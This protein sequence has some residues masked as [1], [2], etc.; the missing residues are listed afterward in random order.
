[1]ARTKQLDNVSDEIFIRQS[2]PD[3]LT[4]MGYYQE[5]LK[6]GSKMDFISATAPLSLRPHLFQEKII[7]NLSL[8]AVEHKDEGIPRFC[9]AELDEGSKIT[10][11]NL[12]GFETISPYAF[13]NSTMITKISGTEDIREIG[14]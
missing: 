11:F 6:N 14:E 5:F 12:E 13:W 2:A 4:D 8:E 3:D 9:F 7:N 1:M 10:E